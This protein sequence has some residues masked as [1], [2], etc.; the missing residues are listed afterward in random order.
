MLSMIL[1]RDSSAGVRKWTSKTIS[2][3]E[4]IGAKELGRLTKMPNF[5][6]IFSQK[7]VV[8]VVKSGADMDK[9]L[10]RGLVET[11]KGMFVYLL[12]YHIAS[13]LNFLFPYLFLFQEKSEVEKIMRIDFLQPCFYLNEMH[14]HT[15]KGQKNEGKSWQCTF[16]I[17]M[18]QF[19]REIWR[20]LSRGNR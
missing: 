15:C 10:V 14:F 11:W 20:E 1:G 4:K 13:F 9:L 5:L 18:H 16:L 8:S 7:D 19:V 12:G 3:L 6:K 2:S 17:K